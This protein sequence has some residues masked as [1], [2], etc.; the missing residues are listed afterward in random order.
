MTFLHLIMNFL[1][2]IF[3]C[4]LKVLGDF[5]TLTFLHL[6]TLILELD[7]DI[8]KVYSHYKYGGFSLDRVKFNDNVSCKYVSMFAVVPIFL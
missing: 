4:F 8:I 5:M 3:N 1:H 6:M 7:L 2:L